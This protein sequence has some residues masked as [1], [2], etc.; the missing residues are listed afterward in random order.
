[1]GA[2]KK[3]KKKWHSQFFSKLPLPLLFDMSFPLSHGHSLLLGLD[4]NYISPFLLS[5]WKLCAWL[6]CRTYCPITFDWPLLMHSGKENKGDVTVQPTMGSAGLQNSHQREECRHI[7]I[8]ST[9]VV[10]WCSV[11]TGW[12]ALTWL[13]S[14]LNDTYNFHCDITL[15]LWAK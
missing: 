1:M 13:I 3:K 4:K 6:Q 12:T 9:L 2:S 11:M 5:P 10:W 8:T 14:S 7:C 15:S